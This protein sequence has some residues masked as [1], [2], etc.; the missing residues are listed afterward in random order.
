MLTVSVYEFFW[1]YNA[2]FTF[3]IPL[4]MSLQMAPLTSLLNIINIIHTLRERQKYCR[5]AIFYSQ[6]TYRF[7]AHLTPFF[8]ARFSWII[9]VNK[10]LLRKYKSIWLNSFLFFFLVSFRNFKNRAKTELCLAHYRV[11][12]GLGLV[13]CSD[14]VSGTRIRGILCLSIVF[15]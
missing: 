10:V 15:L 12:R 7:K 8:F 9:S 2:H 14:V 4:S 11:P 1:R 5:A 3:I 13:T 6:H